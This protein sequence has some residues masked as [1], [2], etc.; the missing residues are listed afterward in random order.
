MLFQII[1]F[2]VHSSL[3]NLENPSKNKNKIF[4]KKTAGMVLFSNYLVIYTQIL[5]E[6]TK[7]F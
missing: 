7:V 6:L 1:C 4:F 5:R 3:L 2:S